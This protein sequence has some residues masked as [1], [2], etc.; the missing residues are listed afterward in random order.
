MSE[1]WQ[2]LRRNWYVVLA[3]VLVSVL[4]ALGYSAAR[5]T[6]YE[7]TATL[8]V[9]LD[10]VQSVTDLAQGA[11]Y[12]RDQMKSYESVVVSPQVT[13]PVVDT[14]KLTESTDELASRIKASTTTDSTVMEI[15]CSAEDPQQASDIC[16]QVASQFQE[17]IPSLA[18]F[19]VKNMG[20]LKADILTPATPAL[21]GAGPST[22]LL[23]G[24]GVV[25]GTALGM[26][27]A[28]LADRMRSR[29]EKPR[30]SRAIA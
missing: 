5:K 28:I 22:S 18:T 20:T 25:G 6:T 24:L 23:L 21:V 12:V 17:H 9:A 13:Q 8:Y 27:A 4:A 30:S 1:Y 16:N 14:L 2:A 26:I 15:T 3:V 11:G 29:T 19:E 10:R 7:S